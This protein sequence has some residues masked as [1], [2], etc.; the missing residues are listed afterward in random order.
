MINLF[1]FNIVLWFAN[2]NKLSFYRIIPI[3][4][5]KYKSSIKNSGN[6]DE[7]EFKAPP[8]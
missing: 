7:K 8:L 1:H 5:Q 4:L 6:L 3:G 2:L